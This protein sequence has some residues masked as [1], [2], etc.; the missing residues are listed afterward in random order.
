VLRQPAASLIVYK[1]LRLRSPQAKVAVKL[2]Y[3]SK[4]T[5]KGSTISDGAAVKLFVND[6]LAAEGETTKA[7]FRHGIEP[8]EVGRDSISPVNPA[9]KSH[10]AYPFSG[11]IDKIV[12]EL[13]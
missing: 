5:P 2:E 8:F 10:G 1:V 13:K 9:Y 7:M 3:A 4:G 12:F 6:K 11:Q